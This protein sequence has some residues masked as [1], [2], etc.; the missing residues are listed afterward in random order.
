M[1]KIITMG[2][3]AFVECVLNGHSLLPYM[4]RV[5]NI[6]EYWIWDFTAQLTHGGAVRVMKHARDYHLYLLRSAFRKKM[7]VS[8][9]QKWVTKS[10]C[11][12]GTSVLITVI[13]P[14]ERY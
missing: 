8:M 5:R 1:R 6:M 4:S 3:L 14:G 2:L 11:V 13:T 10:G 7:P 12:F 9:S